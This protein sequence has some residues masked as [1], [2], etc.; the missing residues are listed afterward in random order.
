MKF[1]GLAV[2]TSRSL[3]TL[4]IEQSN[5]S[6]E[7]GDRFMQG[8]A[9]HRIHWLQNLTFQCEDYWFKGGRDGCM[10]FLIILLA[11]QANLQL[12]N[13]TGYDPIIKI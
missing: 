8:L 5:T 1:A 4:H 6:A 9:D 2:T 13:L 3:H 10:Q 11:R 7:A 12:L